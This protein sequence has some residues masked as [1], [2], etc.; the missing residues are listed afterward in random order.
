MS[1]ELLFVIGTLAT[2]VGWGLLLRVLFVAIRRW[3]LPETRDKETVASLGIALG[4]GAL[5]L[6]VSQV[7]PLDPGRPIEGQIRIPV[8]WVLMSFQGWVTAVSLFFLGA[9]LIQAR[10]ALNDDE[11][12]GRLKS[13]AGWG[14][15]ALFFGWWFWQSDGEFTVFRGA[16]STT[17]SMIVAIVVLAIVAMIVMALAGRAIKVRGFSK[18]ILV[19]VTLLLGCIVFGFPFAWLLITSFKEEK[20]MTSSSGIIW[21]PRVQVTHPYMDEDRPLVR[22]GFE[23]RSV[24]AAVDDK[25]GEGRVLLEIERPYGLRGKR[26]ETLASATTAVPRDAPVVSATMDGVAITGFVAKELDS[27]ARVVEVLTPPEKKGQRFEASSEKLEPVRRNG[28]RWQ[29]YPEALEWM[30]FET[31]YGLR[32]LQNTLVLVI[33]SVIGTVLSCAVVGYGFS[34]LRF[35][36]RNLLFNLM[37]ATMMLPG[38]VTMLPTFLIFRNLGWIDSL[39]P[40]W[41]PTFFAGAFNVFLLKQFFSTIPMELEEAARIDGA[42]YVRTFWQV[43]LPQ[44]KP[45]LAAISIWTFMGAWNNFMGPLIYISSPEKMPVAYALQLFAADRSGQYGMLMAFSAMAIIPVLLLFFA[46]QKYFIEGVQLSG[47]GGR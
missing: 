25:L 16:I 32:Y 44:V 45:A 37:L 41:V 34:R 18:K 9:S 14:A 40:L 26:F 17:M 36:G 4:I 19:H 47:L 13:A 35:P 10:M 15:V 23:G 21:M 28:L 5:L 8:T 12:R 27:G 20:D 24:L 42:G 38:A 30:P 29:N 39:A 22:T 7:I 46:A 3:I 31:N 2:W 43:M 1:P 11:R 33:M 6:I